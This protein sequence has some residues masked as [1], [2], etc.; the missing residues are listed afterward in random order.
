MLVVALGKEA[1]RIGRR[2][3][4]A[5]QAGDIDG[6]GEGPY[7]N[8]GAAPVLHRLQPG[9]EIDADRL[10]FRQALELSGLPHAA[11]AEHRDGGLVGG[12][13]QPLV[14]GDDAERHQMPPCVASSDSLKVGFPARTVR[15]GENASRMC[16]GQAV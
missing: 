5:D 15:A 8:A 11:W 1:V 12:V 3:H 4:A 6:I 7:R 2:V 9:L 16:A 10:A 13:R 14:G